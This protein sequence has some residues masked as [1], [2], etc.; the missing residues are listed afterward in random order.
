MRRIAIAGA[1]V[2]ALVLLGLELLGGQ[3]ALASADSAYLAANRLFNDGRYERAAE[4]YTE[5]LRLKP[6]HLP[7]LRGRANALL[8]SGRP[9]LALEPIDQAISRQPNFGGNYAIRGITLDTLGRHHDAMV[10]YKKAL[11]RDPAIADGMGWFDRFH[12][13][14]QQK[15]PSIADRLRYLQQQ[16]KL[17]EAERVLSRPNID[18]E[19][20]PYER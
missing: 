15:P 6:D 10:D 18:A 17:P 11:E 2:I 12:Y 8:K 20:H 5:A 16:M 3:S 19:Q 1:V 13:N 14:V 7:A 4:A 9:A